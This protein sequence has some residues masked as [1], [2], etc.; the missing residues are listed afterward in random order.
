MVLMIYELLLF[1]TF[2]SIIY[3]IYML[4]IVYVYSKQR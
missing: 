4:Y 1:R 3:F 2:D